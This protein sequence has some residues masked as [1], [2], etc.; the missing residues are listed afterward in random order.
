MDLSLDEQLHENLTAIAD[1]CHKSG[2]IIDVQEYL[3]VEDAY[4]G[5]IT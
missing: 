4:Q 1:F 5:I 3:F 2:W